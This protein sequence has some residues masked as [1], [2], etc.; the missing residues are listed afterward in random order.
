MFICIK[1]RTISLISF[2]KKFSIQF[3]FEG[4]ISN[5]N[6][7]FQLLVTDLDECALDNGGCEDECRNTAGSYHCV[8]HDGFILDE[9]KHRC[10]VGDCRFEIT[11]PTRNVISPNYPMNYSS[12][13]DCY[14][15]FTTTPGHRIRL[16][17][18]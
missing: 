5:D 1:Q 15:H 16:V 10:K 7:K 4:S 13:L 6:T 14:W 8:C 9:D 2:Y 18:I 17:S 12:N 11:A 3:N